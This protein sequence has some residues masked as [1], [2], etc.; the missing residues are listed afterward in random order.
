MIEIIAGIFLGSFVLTWAVAL[1]FFYRKIQP[2]FESKTYQNLNSNLKKV[3]LLWS[4]KNSDFIPYR[5]G[6]LQKDK[7]QSF[8]SFF[9][10]TTLCSLI[11]VAGFLLL[12]LVLLTG[13]SRR[14][15]LVFSSLL[16]NNANLLPEQI[17]PIVTEIKNTH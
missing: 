7:A 14:E 15:R 11:S 2:Q 1:Y 13:K 3:G 16:V 12:F 6:A 9:L 17:L 10:I 8:K 5:E 4:N